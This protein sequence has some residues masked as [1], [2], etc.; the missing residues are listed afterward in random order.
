MRLG[1][2]FHYTSMA[3]NSRSLSPTD[4]DRHR[5]TY[6]RERRREGDRDGD[7]GRRRYDAED[8]HDRS[9]RSGRRGR[10]SDAK[11]EDRKGERDGGDYYDKR[12]RE[13]REDRGYRDRGAGPSSQRSPVSP[14]RRSARARSRSP[15]RQ[16]SRSKSV[17]S[18]KEK[19][20]GKPNFS[21]S[22]LLAAETNKV[23]LADG[24]STVLKYNEPPE[25][26]KPLIGWR[27]YVF[28]GKE[29]SGEQNNNVLC[30]LADGCADMLHIQRQ[31]AYLVG[32]DKAVVDIYVEHPSCSKQHA[33]I[34]RESGFHVRCSV[35]NLS[36]CVDR[37]VQEKDE[38]G[39]SKPV[40]KYVSV[41]YSASLLLILHS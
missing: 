20:K 23:K 25:A 2:D 36:R 3:H 17:V 31:S 13:D 26:R 41:T 27:L 6:D 40:I 30:L 28:K 10:E 16:R 19:E 38:F 11:R 22:G 14:P 7:Y 35:S 29:Q 9:R 32:R 34:Q 21:Q 18:E 1:D 39:I 15:S 12:R 33:V 24:A 8:E 4:R 37:Q 5:Q